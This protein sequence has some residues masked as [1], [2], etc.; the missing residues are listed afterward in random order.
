MNFWKTTT[1]YGIGFIALRA[2]SFLL[3]PLYTNLLSNAEAGWVFIIYTLL[4]LLNVFY[5]HGMN[6]ALL[7]FFHSSNK[8][9]IV[10]TSTIYAIISSV[11]LSLFLFTVYS[12]YAKTTGENHHLIV[13]FMLIIA[14]LDMLSAKNN[15]I[16]R[17][18]ERPL[19]Y[20]FICLVNVLLSI[21]LNIYFIQICNQGIMGAIHSL[22]IVAIIQFLLLV[23]IMWSFIRITLFN[24]RLL[25]QMLTVG[26][27]FFPAA[28]FFVFIE[29]SD[30]WMLG[31][32]LNIHEVG[33]YGAG[34][35]IGS[36]VL[37]LVN[38]FNLNWQPY[39]LKTKLNKGIPVFE[40]IGNGFILI[41][42][43]I[44]TIL[45]SFWPV[46]FNIKLGSYS[47]IGQDFWEGGRIIPIICISY[48]FY[49]I[50]IL[51]MPS[52]FL[53][54]KQKWAPIIWGSGLIINVLSNLMLIPVYGMFG[55]AYATLFAYITMSAIII[56]KNYHWMR[57]KYNL[58]QIFSFGVKIKK[59][60][61]RVGKTL[62]ME[63]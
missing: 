47:I 59:I 10:T 63:N 42:V 3:L 23:P 18:L 1:I 30:R 58:Q 37:L 19:Y 61:V 11:V 21:G 35:K 9:E 55:A 25:L 43:F 60:V 6:A 5:T 48:I 31:Y 14:S 54:T 36:V 26:M 34:Y 44:S 33:L 17:L 32:L 28:L 57:L 52:I 51:Q 46:L 24:Y 27:S 12:I 4:A 45:A 2:I 13:I 40:K 62:H 20:L 39:Y 22:L 56:F 41:L 29:L 53:K 15:I 8:Q 50:F 49:G 7:K 38:S 16:L